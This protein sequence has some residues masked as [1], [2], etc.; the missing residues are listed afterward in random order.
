MTILSCYAAHLMLPRFP[1]GMDSSKQ[2]NITNT[3]RLGKLQSRSFGPML[4]LRFAA[5]FECDFES[6]H[7][8]GEYH[9]RAVE[10]SVAVVVVAWWEC[11]TS[12]VVL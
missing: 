1:H 10:S 6:K 8:T 7:C 2:G 12:A 5:G 3:R 11:L 9:N 4:T